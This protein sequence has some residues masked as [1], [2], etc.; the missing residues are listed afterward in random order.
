M[1]VGFQKRFS[2]EISIVFPLAKRPFGKFKF[3]VPR[4]TQWFL[5]H[6]YDVNKCLTNNYDHQHE[7]KL[8]PITVDC[9]RLYEIY[10]F[11]IRDRNTANRNIENIYLNGTLLNSV[12]IN[13]INQH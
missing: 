11:V 4:D 10:S 9:K 7:R 8:I 5:G 13:M 1:D 6:G 3:S 12:D 2:F